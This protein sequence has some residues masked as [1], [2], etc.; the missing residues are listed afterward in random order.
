MEI[1]V[2]DTLDTKGMAC[3]M[4]IVKTKKA[5][6]S[7]GHGHVIEVLA[8]DRGSTA[9]L[10]AWADTTGH[11]YLGTIEEGDVLKHYIRKGDESEPSDSVAHQDRLSLDDLST[12]VT[13]DDHVVL[14]DVR[15]HAEFAFGHI[16]G[17]VNIPLGELEDR[18]D[19]VSKE[20]EVCVI[21]RTGSR[22]DLAA[23]KL[24]YH[25][26]AQVKNVVP[27]MSDWNGPIEQGTQ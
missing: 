4:P 8:T 21:C 12:R 11:L 19:E 15:E 5:L 27:G 14:I 20:Y 22:S 10:K 13:N 6:N 24:A 25:G 23:Q 1:N 9:D 2:N 16:P 7:I 17:A 26:Y 3:P 18:L